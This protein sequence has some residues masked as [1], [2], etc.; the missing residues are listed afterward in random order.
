MSYQETA[1]FRSRR[2]EWTAAA[3]VAVLTALLLSTSANAQ[4]SQ[5]AANPNISATQ[6][7]K[8]FQESV[9][10]E[11]LREDLGGDDLKAA[12]A[13][14]A[15]GPPIVVPGTPGGPVA[16]GPDL[17]N[18]AE[19][20]AQNYGQNPFGGG[21]TNLGTVYHYS[22]LLVDAKLKK[23]YPWRVT[24]HFAFVDASGSSFR[25]TASLIAPSILVTAGHCVHQGGNGASGW[26]RSGAFYPAR[27]GS[28]FPYGF[29]TA[30]TF[31]T[32][33]GWYNTGDI[34]KG[35]DVGLVVLNKRSGKDKEIGS[36]TGTYG[37]C[38][39]N[40]LQTYWQLTQ[41]GYPANYY[42]G[43]NMTEGQHIENNRDNTDYYH[44]SGMQ[45]GSSGGPH[46]ANIGSLSD[47]TANKGLWPT[48]NV[49]FSVTSWGYVS[50]IYKIQGSSTL[51]GPGNSNNF[52][53]MYNVACNRARVLHGPGA[54]TLQ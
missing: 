35:Y 14:P 37:F 33:T 51:S 27:T 6:A 30:D 28:E 18:P 42:S 44:G 15:D 8:V 10:A 17:E 52:V 19:Q 9:P 43:V 41:L 34:V 26:N 47:S 40:C 20:G 29:A 1:A 11:R 3:S 54:C 4:V 36:W 45:G 13:R 22:D 5:R 53:A 50:D 23:R 46:I 39:S 49:V 38:L 48:R 21:G 24:G 16:G 7:E 32:T 2:V 31:V 12:K 25:C